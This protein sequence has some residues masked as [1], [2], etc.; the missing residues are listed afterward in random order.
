MPE[1]MSES[2]S[3]KSNLIEKLV[4]VLVIISIGLSFSVGYL[5]QKVETLSKGGTLASDSGTNVA[6]TENAQAPSVPT[7]GK[8]SDDRAA[9]LPGVSSI[10]EKSQGKAGF[11]ISNDDHVRGSR[12][13]QV[14]LIE[15]SDLQCPY[16]AQFHST[17][18]QAVDD[19]DGK[20][21]WV[22]RHFP[23]ETLHPNAREAANAAECVA[24]TAGEDGFWSF[25]DYVFANQSTALTN[26]SQAAKDAGVSSAS[27]DSCLTAKTYDS[28]IDDEVAGGTSAGVTGTPGNFIVNDKG[29]VWVIPGAVPYSSLKQTIDEALQS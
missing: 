25:V 7:S 12:D 27:F 14:Y 29:E 9:A 22:Y 24:N 15:Y 11:T 16:C 2:S 26:L 23:L 6:G 17:A 21:A 13:A 8:L 4:P 18:Q 1:S 5:W 19:Y 3:T 20:V 10:D 28:K